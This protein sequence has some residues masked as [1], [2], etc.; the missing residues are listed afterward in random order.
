[1]LTNSQWSNSKQTR[2]TNHVSQWS[3]SSY[4]RLTCPWCLTIQAHSYYCGIVGRWGCGWWSLCY[5]NSC[6]LLVV[7]ST[8]S[9]PNS[10]FGTEDPK[11]SYRRQLGRDVNHAATRGWDCLSDCGEKLKVHMSVFFYPV[12]PYYPTPSYKCTSLSRPAPFL[13]ADQSLIWPSV[14]PYYYPA[15]HLYSKWRLFSRTCSNCRRRRLLSDSDRSEWS[16]N[17]VI[18]FF[19]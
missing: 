6:R 17:T 4:C 11:P 18:I 15:W 8:G 13:S 2:A 16:G 1:M 14:W 5:L 12:W 7:V 3:T 9:S 19:A 10:F